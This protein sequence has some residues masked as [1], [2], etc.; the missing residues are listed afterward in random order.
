VTVNSTPE[1]K[2]GTVFDPA[3]VNQIRRD[4]AALERFY[5]AYYDD[6]VRYL[7][8]RLHDPHD[9]ADLVADTF[10]AAVDA[11][12]SYDHRRGGPLPWLI[13]IAHNKLRRWYR[14]QN[15]DRDLAHRAVG[16]RL[17][18]ADDIADLEARIDAQASGAL[19]ALD[20]LTPNQRE[21][22]DLV[23]LQGFTP[24]EAARVLGVSAG[25]ARIRLYR[26]RKALR[27]TLDPDP[28]P[29][30]PRSGNGQERK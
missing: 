18:D 28:G 29:L 1:A 19:K 23:D 9:V 27:N 2:V 4:A 6:V 10:L 25:V 16:R 3:E 11:A 22:I 21:L 26:A 17:L 12:G 8:R 7:V 14:R 30:D 20:R 15:A 24:A 5:L 13:G